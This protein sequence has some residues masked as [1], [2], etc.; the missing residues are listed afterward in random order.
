MSK[1]LE[2]IAID[3]PSGV[4]KST[5]SKKIAARL[6]YTYLDTGA[7]YRAVGFHL[8]HQKVDLENVEAIAA[9]LDNIKLCL[10]P[11]QNE[12]SE[13]GIMLNMEDISDK[14]RTPEMSMLASRVS[15]LSVV[16]T[17]LTRMQREIGLQERIV[18]EGRDVGTTVFPDAA[19]KYFLDGDI[20]VRSSRRVK[21]LRESGLDADKETILAMIRKRDKDDSERDISPLR[22]AD[23]A[24]LIDTTSITIE[25]V[26]D[27]ILTDVLQQKTF[28]SGKN[29]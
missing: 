8:K 6:G 26:C 13:A 28:E 29:L 25:D 17:V 14:I 1:K 10:L 11:S 27:I 22:K 5:V 24:L 23:D 3:G 18:A 7:M 16:R 9:S 15:A 19:Y 4:G 2:I 21:Q 12:A 20:Q